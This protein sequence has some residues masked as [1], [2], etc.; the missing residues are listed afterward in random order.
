[1]TN[2]EKRAAAVEGLGA[3]LAGI[4]TGDLPFGD[5]EKISIE[6]ALL[7]IDSGRYTVAL[8]EIDCAICPAH[9]RSPG[10]RISARVASRTLD[11][12]E[13]EFER[14]MRHGSASPEIAIEE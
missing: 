14:A 11:E 4:R 12:Y 7:L 1:M 9:N 3:I 2:A 8:N 10:L 5:W 6:N 13:R